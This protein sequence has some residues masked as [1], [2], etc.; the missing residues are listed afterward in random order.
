MTNEIIEK[1]LTNVDSQKA[2]VI[3][4]PWKIEPTN[5]L[6]NGQSDPIT[7]I[8]IRSVTSNK[9]NVKIKGIPR[10]MYGR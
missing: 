8:N 1:L 7:Q 5:Q 4:L 9:K 2:N 3:Y 6:A 10:H